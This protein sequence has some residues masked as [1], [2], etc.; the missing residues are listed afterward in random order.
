MLDK[1]PGFLLF[2]LFGVD[3]F[4]DVTVPVAEGVHLGGTAGFAAGFYDVGY[5]V[6][7]LEK[8]KWTARTPA[9]AEFLLTRSDGGKIG[10]GAGAIFEEHGLGVGEVHDAFHVILDGLDEAGAALGIFMLSL[11]A[12]GDAGG[13]VVEPVTARGVF[14]DAVL[15]VETDI[16]PDGELKAPCWLAQSQVSSS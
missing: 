16:E 11:G 9:A 6:I 5:L 1:C 15:S 7:D 14:A 4:L 8:A 13:A 3:E 2:L 10:A 12:F